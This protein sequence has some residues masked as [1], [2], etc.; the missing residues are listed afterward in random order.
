MVNIFHT[1][2][3]GIHLRFNDF[4]FLSFFLVLGFELRVKRLQKLYHASHIPTS[5]Y[6]SNFGDRVLS[7][8]PG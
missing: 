8:Y 7:F 5:L 4:S 3:E 6:F 1:G 2:R